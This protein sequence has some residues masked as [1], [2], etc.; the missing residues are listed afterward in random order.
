MVASVVTVIVAFHSFVD[1]SMQTE[2]V[3]I[4]WTALLATG[5]AQSWSGRISTSAPLVRRIGERA[6][7]AREGGVA[8]RLHGIREISGITPSVSLE[9]GAGEE[10]MLVH[11]T[12]LSKNGPVPDAVLDQ[13]RG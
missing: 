1:F 10:T 9:P 8:P 6:V 13:R 7:S 3:A 11:R 12:D 2:A 4:T 5:V